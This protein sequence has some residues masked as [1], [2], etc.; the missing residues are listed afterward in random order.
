MNTLKAAYRILN[1]LEHKD[2]ERA[3]SAQIGPAAIG[4]EQADWLEVMQ[5]LLDEGYITGVKIITDML[6]ETS[7]DMRQARI[8]LKGAEYLHENSAMK[9]IADLAADIISIVK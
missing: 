2:R 4:M 9:K 3:I 6:G 1:A 8:T 7:V 5:S